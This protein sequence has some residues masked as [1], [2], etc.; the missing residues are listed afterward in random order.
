MKKEKKHY[1]IK[2]LIQIH[3][4][5]DLKV[6]KYLHWFPVLVGK[7]S[8]LQQKIRDGGEGPT[9]PEN[10]RQQIMHNGMK[11]EINHSFYA[12][13]MGYYFKR[14]CSRETG[15]ELHPNNGEATFIWR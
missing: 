4:D 5:A 3:N 15:T 1:F 2:R 7:E 14:A 6:R 10:T 9:G 12:A 8:H 11:K 13:A